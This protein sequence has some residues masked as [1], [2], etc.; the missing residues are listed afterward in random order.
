MSR[1]RHQAQRS[2]RQRALQARQ[3][4]TFL[5]AVG[6]FATLRH[7]CCLMPCREPPLRSQDGDRRSSS[8][9][10]VTRGAHASA[11]RQRESETM[12]DVNA[13]ALISA[14]SKR[15]GVRWQGHLA[16]VLSPPRERP[17]NAPRDLPDVR[18][19]ACVRSQC[20]RR[21]CGVVRIIVCAGVPCGNRTIVL[22]SQ[23][24]AALAWCQLFFYGQQIT[25]KPSPC[26]GSS[27]LRIEPE[28]RSVS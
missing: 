24:T 17:Q 1:R 8:G 5:R 11:S 4:L 21:V 27:Y 15:P 10:W 26:I 2:C 19:I 12:V 14:P 18:E 16:G 25:R 20:L 13:Q 9:Q 22:R 3:A 28:I 6:F 7:L 23:T